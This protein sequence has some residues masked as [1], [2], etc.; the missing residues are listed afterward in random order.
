MSHFIH[1]PWPQSDYWYVLPE[2]LRRSVHEGLLANDIVG[3]HTARWKRNFLRTCEELLGAEVDD[4]AGTVT[5][6]GAAPS[7]RAI[8][9]GSTRSSSTS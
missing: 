2:H 1:I 7:S 8:R 3:F 4:R 5:T 6:T 9:S